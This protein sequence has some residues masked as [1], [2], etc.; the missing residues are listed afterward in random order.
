MKD[1]VAQGLNLEDDAPLI[2]VPRYSDLLIRMH[3]ST[4][5]TQSVADGAGQIGS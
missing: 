2:S 4:S 5:L 3:F 1:G